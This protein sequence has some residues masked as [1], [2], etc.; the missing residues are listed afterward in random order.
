[1]KAV[2]ADITAL[3]KSGLLNRVKDGRVEFPYETVKIEFL[4]QAA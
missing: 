2:H 4:L 1:V 3:L